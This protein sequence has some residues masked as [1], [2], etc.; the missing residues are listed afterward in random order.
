MRIVVASALVFGGIA[1]VR[2]TPR[3][4]PADKAARKAA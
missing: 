2:S 3:V 4:A 1:I